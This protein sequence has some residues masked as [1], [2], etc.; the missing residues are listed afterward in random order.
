MGKE[1]VLEYSKLSPDQIKIINRIFFPTK[2]ET[3]DHYPIH[4]YLKDQSTWL[5]PRDPLATTKQV[6]DFIIVKLKK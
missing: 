6:L 1:V 5:A 4:I 3:A 2:K